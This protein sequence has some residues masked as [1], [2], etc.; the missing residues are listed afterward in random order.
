[1]FSDFASAATFSVGGLR[2]NKQVKPL[3]EI[4]R[5]N[6]VTQSL[7]FSC[8]A[9]GL[10]TVLNYYLEDPVSE[11]EIIQALLQ[12]VPLEK[13]KQRRGF[14]LLDLKKFAEHKGYRVTGYKMDFDFLRELG[15]PVLVPIK[16]KNYRHFV[17]VKAV[18]GDR[19]FLADPAVG[20]VSVKDYKF[21][22]MWGGGIGLV[23]EHAED[24]NIAHSD[25]SV[26]REDIIIADLKQYKRLLDQSLYRTAIYNT[27]FKQ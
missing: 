13:V 1:M 20:N 15:K 27:E 18:I 22:K 25:L 26:D 2:L 21:R 16:F 5:S 4:K 3:R 7:D 8:G 23:I 14:S 24:E 12:L 17:I 6:V 10:S 9:A 19:V 11:Q